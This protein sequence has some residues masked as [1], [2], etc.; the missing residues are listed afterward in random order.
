[1]AEVV[2]EVSI[3]ASQQQREKPRTVKRP[4]EKQLPGS[5]GIGALK[6]AAANRTR[7]V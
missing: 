5:T 1:M 7:Y 2:E 3:V 4:G 6:A